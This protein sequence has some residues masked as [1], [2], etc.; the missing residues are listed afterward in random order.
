[1]RYSD[2][3]RASVLLLGSA[4]IALIIVAASALARDGSTRTAILGGIWILLAMLVGWWLGRKDQ[5]MESLGTLLSR[6]RPEPV[7]PKIEPA[8]V[9]LGRLWPVLVIVI[10]S[11]LLTVWFTQLAVAAAG[12]GLLWAIAWR[13]QAMAV[14][15]IEDRDAVH[16]WIVRSS[17]WHPPK[18][19]RVPAM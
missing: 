6:S 16:F 2:F 14:E 10:V 18:L 3:L 15:A 11:A 19:V 1:M 17:P 7:F 9:L 4:A 8:A 13:K 12:Y 5:V